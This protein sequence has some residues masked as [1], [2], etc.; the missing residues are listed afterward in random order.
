MGLAA[1]EFVEP[2]GC[3]V[4]CDDSLHALQ[5]VAGH[6][7]VAYA[8]ERGRRVE[9]GQVVFGVVVE[10]EWRVVQ[11]RQ[12]GERVAVAVA[13]TFLI[14]QWV[15]WLGLVPSD[16]Q[17]CV[18]LV[19]PPPAGGDVITEMFGAGDTVGGADGLA[20]RVFHLVALVGQGCGRV[21]GQVEAVVQVTE[22]GQ[23]HECAGV[24]IIGEPVAA[25]LRHVRA[26]GAAGEREQPC[27]RVIVVADILGGDDGRCL[28]EQVTQLRVGEVSDDAGG[29]GSGF[30]CGDVRNGA[31]VLGEDETHD[32]GRERVGAFLACFRAEQLHVMHAFTERVCSDGVLAAFEHGLVAHG[33]ADAQHGERI[34]LVAIGVHAGDVRVLP[35]LRHETV[36]ITH[37]C[38]DQGLPSHLFAPTGQ[39]PFTV[40]EA[41]GQQ[42]HDRRE[43]CQSRRRHVEVGEHAAGEQRGAG[44]G[45]AHDAFS[46]GGV[47]PERGDADAGAGVA[48]VC[49]TVDVVLVALAEPPCAGDIGCPHPPCGAVEA[50]DGAEH[51]P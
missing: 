47:F 4:G 45:G 3:G 21:G 27:G 22:H 8:D 11:E 43:C 49:A 33:Y 18:L 10:G 34:V 35:V 40:H 29:L 20:G 16:G 25:D 30:A 50:G 9:G 37:P 17:P 39:L 36:V 24:G 41:D 19:L 5:A 2:G 48:P 12:R 15:R 7:V 31:F 38:V 32:V 1:V 6:T 44:E 26:G 23:A 51:G 42:E 14:E 13:F 28:A 46:S